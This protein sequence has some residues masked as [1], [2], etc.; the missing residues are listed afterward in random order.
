MKNVFLIV[1]C[2]DYKSTMHLIDNIISYKS[3]EEIII[4]DNAS[5]HDELIKLNS[6]KRKKVKIIYNASNDG[7]SSAINIGAKYLIKKYSKCNIFISNSDIVI[8]SEND[9]I[10]MLEVLSLNNVGLVGPQILELGSIHRGMREL[11]PTM[12]FLL[13]VPILKNLI[14]DNAYQYEEGHYEKETSNVDVIS[15]CFF[16]ISSEVLEKINYMD[17]SVFLYYEDFILSKKIRNLGLDIVVQNEVKVKH[18]YSVS[19]DRIVKNVDKYKMLKKSQFYYHTTYNNANK[20]ERIL[21]KVNAFLGVL[22]RKI[23]KIFHK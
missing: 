21:L 3:I 15:S 19:V 14:S 13:T 16:L 18:L 2:N 12:D 4:V 23:K 6:I 7:Y 10:K 11:T 20:A 22:V 17:E 9:L 1:N 5:R 8:M